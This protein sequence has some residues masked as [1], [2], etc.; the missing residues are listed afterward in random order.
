MRCE[1]CGAAFSPKRSDA[2]YCG[3]RCRQR[4]CRTRRDLADTD[5]HVPLTLGD[6]TPTLA[7]LDR[8]LGGR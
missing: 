2:R 4:A 7:D 8:W 3:A 5:R 1:I 6:L